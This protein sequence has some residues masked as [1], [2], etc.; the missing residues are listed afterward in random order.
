[1]CCSFK[2]KVGGTCGFDS[3]DRR[4]ED[5]VVP[6]LSCKKP[7]SNHLVSWSFSGPES[8]VDLILCRAGI[9]KAPDSLDTMTICPLHRGK[10]GVGWK[11]GSSRC[12]IPAA[13]SKHGLKGKKSWPTGDRGLT[14]EDSKL[15]LRETGTFVQP[16]S[17]IY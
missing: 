8:E 1:M 6:L 14:R 17:G 9:F 3:G 16:G 11:R 2:S 13:I 12:R 4:Q 10:L 15:V 5:K 7:I